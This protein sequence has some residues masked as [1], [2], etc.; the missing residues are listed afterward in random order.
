MQGLDRYLNMAADVSML[1]SIVRMRDGCKVQ[2]SY[3]SCSGA[4]M[5]SLMLAC[6]KWRFRIDIGKSQRGPAGHADESEALRQGPA[7]EGK[8][9]SSN[10]CGRRAQRTPQAKEHA[11]SCTRHKG[12]TY[13]ATHPIRCEN[14][15]GRA[16]KRARARRVRANLEDCDQRVHVHF[17][18]AQAESLKAR[19][20]QMG[21]QRL[22]DMQRKQPRE[23]HRAAKRFTSRDCWS[24]LSSSSSMP[25]CE[26]W[27]R[28]LP[29]MNVSS[30]RAGKQP[31]ASSSDGHRKAKQR[32]DISSG[33]ALRQHAKLALA[34]EGDEGCEHGDTEAYGIQREKLS[35]PRA[36]ERCKHRHEKHDV[37]CDC[38][39]SVPEQ[40]AQRDATQ[41][42]GR[43][44]CMHACSV[45]RI[46][47]QLHSRA[48]LELQK[49]RRHRFGA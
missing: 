29:I 15:M 28:N 1:S 43:E 49:R 2:S 46:D 48:H 22:C 47:Q 14:E 31:G 23:A 9:R 19:C 24:V 12:R 4:N 16:E 18:A 38:T 42:G 32:A 5:H 35:H 10:A 26:I 33:R 8:T 17:A 41:T 21:W 3:R 13:F 37:A 11:R 7:A 27:L 39:L 34:H 6:K 45:P 20:G 30:T 36:M 40:A 25:K 44:A